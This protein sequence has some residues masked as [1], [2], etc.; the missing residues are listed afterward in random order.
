MVEIPL[1]LSMIMMHNDDDGGRA[2]KS[3]GSSK[4]DSTHERKNLF[5]IYDG[6]RCLYNLKLQLANGLLHFVKD[7]TETS[8][9][10][11]ALQ[12]CCGRLECFVQ[13]VCSNQ[14]TV[15]AL[16]VPESSCLTFGLPKG[17]WYPPP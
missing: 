15:R 6:F 17:G 8:L 12:R 1:C 16:P 7:P 10:T 3:C 5:K 2:W 11:V 14:S 9:F 13:Y 4:T